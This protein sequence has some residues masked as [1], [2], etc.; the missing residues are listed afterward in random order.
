MKSIRLI[1][2]LPRCGGTIISKC[3]GAQ[4]DVVLLSE[5][6]PEGFAVSKK[7]GSPHLFDPIHQ[8][9]KWNN[10]F[11]NKEYEK[12]CNSNFNFEEKIDLI[13]KKTELVNKRLIIRGWAFV[14]IF[15]KPFIE[16]S[17]KDSLTEILSK[18]FE[19]L[20]LYVI[21]HPLECFISCYNSLNFFRHYD[22][23]FF[24]K[25]YRNF[26]LNASNKN[27]FTYENFLLEPEKNLKN[28]CNILKVDYDDD[29]LS[30]LK[31]IKLTGDSKAKNSINI[32]NKENVAERFLKKDDLEKIKRN[33]EYMNLMQDL[34][35]YY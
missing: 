28:M 19:V 17:Y 15:G 22:L 13:Y 23:N 6:H 1:H 35:D 7:M 32:Q 29:Y 16:P 12:I 34:K 25:G 11:E 14:D 30:K 2:N 21:R 20:S 3:V 26:F 5:I 27:I 8:S 18:K 9:Q 31:N 24:F 33:S 4:K 10:L